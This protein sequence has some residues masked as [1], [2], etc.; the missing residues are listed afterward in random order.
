MD[1]IEKSVLDA[2]LEKQ[3][4]ELEEL[5]FGSEEYE[6]AANSIA[7]MTKASAETRKAKSDEKLKAFEKIA[8]IVTATAAL[9]TAGFKGV[10]VF[11]KR[12][13]NKDVLK[14]EETDYVNSKAF[15]NR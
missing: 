11:L 7:S 9:A 12:K 10:E 1:K 8:T 4:A 6:R 13:T 14:V 15:D 3:I 2:A 5:E